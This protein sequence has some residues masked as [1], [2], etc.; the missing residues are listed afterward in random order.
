M[1]KHERDCADHCV[2]GADTAVGVW[3]RRRLPDVCAV[4]AAVVAAV[5]Q[6]CGRWVIRN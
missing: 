3:R 6:L 4:C 2:S 1:D 5:M